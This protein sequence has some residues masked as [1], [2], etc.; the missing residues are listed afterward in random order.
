MRRCHDLQGFC[1][2]PRGL[3]RLQSPSQPHRA[4]GEQGSLISWEKG[5]GQGSHI[6]G[7]FP[8]TT[9]P[10]HHLLRQLVS[11][12]RVRA[13]SGG[14]VNDRLLVPPPELLI[15]SVGGGVPSLTFLKDSHVT[16]LHLVHTWRTLSCLPSNPALMLICMVKSCWPM[17]EFRLYHSPCSLANTPPLCAFSICQLE[18]VMVIGCYEETHTKCLAPED[19]S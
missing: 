11:I 8:L 13:W 18:T 7:N 6:S 15:P 9:Q 5:S 4:A 16:L 3:G 10:T 14:L 19:G 1:L 2:I 12:L 17:G